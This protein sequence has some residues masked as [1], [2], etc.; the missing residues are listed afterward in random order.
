[1]V[2]LLRCPASA[3]EAEIVART[4]AAIR[5]VGGLRERFA[6]KRKIVLKPNIGIDRVRVTRGRQTELTEPAGVGAGG[7]PL[8]EGTGAE[9]LIGDAPTDDTAPVLYEKLGYPAMAARYPRVRMVDFGEGPFVEVPVPGE[10]LQFQRYWLHRDV[11]EADAFVSVA[12]M[13]AH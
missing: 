2:S 4:E 8:R 7:G 11:A 13:K 10:P 12:K 1:R 5:M 6:G 3:P 9:L